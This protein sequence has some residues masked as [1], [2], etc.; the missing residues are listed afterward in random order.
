MNARHHILFQF[1]ALMLLSG[2]I[3]AQVAQSK[4]LDSLKRVIGLRRNDDSI[5]VKLLIRIGYQYQVLQSDSALNYYRE[6]L[7]LAK[8]IRYLKGISGACRQIANGFDYNF[9]SAYYYLQLA[10]VAARQSKDSAAMASIYYDISYKLES[11]ANI[12]GRENSSNLNLDA[13]AFIDSAVTIYRSTHNR[14][15]LVDALARQGGILMYLK[16]MPE[17]RAAL[18]EAST[19]QQTDHLKGLSVSHLYHVKGEFHFANQEFDSALASYRK[20]LVIL[21][22]EKSS[23]GVSYTLGLIGLTYSKIGNF[24]LALESAEKGLKIA[25]DNHLM[26]EKLDLIT[27]FYKIYKDKKDYVNALTYYEELFHLT[28]SLNASLLKESTSKFNLRFEAQ[29]NRER[30]TVLTKDRQIQEQK[31]SRQQILLVAS[32]VGIILLLILAFV[33][34]RNFKKQRLANQQLKEAQEQLIRS[35]K[36]AAFGMLA[37]RVAHEIQNPLNFVNNFSELSKDLVE[38]VVNADNEED[39]KENAELLIGNLSKINEHGLRM[40]SI[41]RQLQ[42][43]INKGTVHE[44]FESENEN[45]T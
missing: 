2:S 33:I 38:D 18:E 41:V 19:I 5:K 9:D 28:D 34:F 24:K 45:K 14:N 8:K 25:T 39:K 43:H 31:A 1:A 42:G 11:G 10:V 37:T 4:K 17:A 26:K 21:E 36:L 40:A 20:A 30:I 29:Q 35:E 22:D 13:L 44:F 15:K 27:V 23:R 7:A 32:A 3:S 12:S 16:R 6:A